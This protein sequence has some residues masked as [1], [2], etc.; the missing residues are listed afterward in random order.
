M[1]KT[2]CCT[3]NR[4]RNNN[5]ESKPQSLLE[6]KRS[7]LSTDG[8]VQLDGGTFLMGSQDRSFPADGEGPIREVTLN[9]FW[10]DT[11]AVTNKQFAEFV[12]QTHYVTEAERFGWSFVFHQFLPNEMPPTRA[13]PNASWWRQVF[14]ATWDHPEGSHSH[15]ADRDNHPVVHISWHDAKAYALWCGKR[16]PTE[17][18]WEYAARG[19]LRQKRYPWGD[20]LLVNRKHRCNIWQGK[21]PE[22]N[23]KADGFLGTCPVDAF[24]PNRYGLYNMSGNVWE[25]CSDW[26]SPTYH[27]HAPRNNPKGPPSGRAKVLKGGSYLCHKSYCNR[28][29]VSA[30]THN[31]TDST[32]GHMG[33]RLVLDAT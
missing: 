24:R 21:F 33:M 10:I 1:S 19:G 13:V 32:T 28:Y 5:E 11:T 27:Q 25:W 7:P 4:A 29:R 6:G 31:T 23:S 16:L 18:E 9:R 8:M 22:R 3:P 2:T 15:I 26:F 17:A 14:G 20:R 30:R 12:K